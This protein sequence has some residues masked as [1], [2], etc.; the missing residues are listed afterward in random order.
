MAGIKG[1]VIIG[2]GKMPYKVVGDT[3]YHK[4]GGVWKVKQHCKSNT[5]AKKAVN[6]LR[7]VEHGWKPTGKKK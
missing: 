5:A 3:V 7:G 6:L 2:E 1:A 4:K